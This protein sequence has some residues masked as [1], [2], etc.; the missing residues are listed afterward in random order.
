MEGATG[1]GQKKVGVEGERE[2]L[3]IILSGPSGGRGLA[4]EKIKNTI[5]AAKRKKKGLG[6]RSRPAGEG[7]GSTKE[8]KKGKKYNSNSSKNC[9]QRKKKEQK[10]RGKKVVN[11][12]GGINEIY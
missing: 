11:E 8:K 9:L 10:K 6:L 1:R 2:E 4:K 12:Q 3:M 7:E 5:Y